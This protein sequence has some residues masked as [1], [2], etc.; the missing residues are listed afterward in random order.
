MILSLTGTWNIDPCGP[1]R[2]SEDAEDL[3]SIMAGIALS[4]WYVGESND[5]SDTL[6]LETY[7]ANEGSAPVAG[8]LPSIML[9]G[10]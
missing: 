7:S 6:V 10:L 3:S 8:Y 4:P 5:E 2:D 9:V 1:L